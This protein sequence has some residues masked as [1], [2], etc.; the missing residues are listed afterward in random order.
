MGEKGVGKLSQETPPPREGEPMGYLLAKLYTARAEGGAC[1]T[2]PPP[3]ERAARWASAM[4]VKVK[5]TAP[6][7]GPSLL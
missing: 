4:L 7:S 6:R 2:L 1:S 5:N 3:A